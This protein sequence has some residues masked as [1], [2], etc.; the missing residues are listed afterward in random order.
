MVELLAAGA[1][2]ERFSFE[3]AEA[4]TTAGRPAAGSS[5]SISPELLAGPEWS[6]HC[7]GFFRRFEA[8]EGARLPGSRRHENRL[9]MAPRKINAALIERIRA[10]C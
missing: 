10:L 3:A 4:E 8:I 5:C 2:G 9:S 1:V 7:E 6:E